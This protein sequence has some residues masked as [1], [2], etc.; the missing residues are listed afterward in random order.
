MH[1]T[2][3]LRPGSHLRMQ[4]L[5]MRREGEP[6][7]RLHVWH[8]SFMATYIKDT[9]RLTITLTVLTLMPTSCFLSWVSELTSV[10]TFDSPGSSTIAERLGADLEFGYTSS[11]LKVT[12]WMALSSE[13]SEAMSAFTAVW[14][15]WAADEMDSSNLC[16]FM[17]P[18]IFMHHIPRICSASR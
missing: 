15:T 10:T 12:F 8:H 16:V 18:L 11:R 2:T 17:N 14:V 7:S 5:D 13:L 4:L 6:G 1:D 9:E 3:S